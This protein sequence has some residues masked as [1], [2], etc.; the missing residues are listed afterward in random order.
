MEVIRD[1]E[2]IV[3]Y[4]GRYMQEKLTEFDML[5]CKVVETPM[6]TSFPAMQKSEVKKV[7]VYKQAIGSMIYLATQ[8]RPD[9]SFAVGYLSR[10]MDSYVVDHWTAVKRIWK[11]ISGTRD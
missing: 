3:L 10:Y 5:G 6:D 11:Y 4:Q 1:E 7:E 9:L 8:T 2:G